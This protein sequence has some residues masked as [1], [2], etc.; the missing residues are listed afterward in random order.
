MLLVNPLTRLEVVQSCLPTCGY[1]QVET[2][3]DHL[4]QTNGRLHIQ[5]QMAVVLRLLPMRCKY[6]STRRLQLRG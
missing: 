5:S 6:T 4:A 3:S 2:Q 1:S